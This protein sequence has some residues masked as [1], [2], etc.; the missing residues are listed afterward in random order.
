MQTGLRLQSNT[1]RDLTLLML[2]VFQGNPLLLPNH[3]SVSLETKKW[4]VG[5]YSASVVETKK[6][7]KKKTKKPQHGRETPTRAAAVAVVVGRSLAV[8][9]SSVVSRRIKRRKKQRAKRRWRQRVTKE[10][11][12]KDLCNLRGL[13]RDRFKAALDLKSVCITSASSDRSEN[14]VSF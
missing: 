13:H 5:T 3:H 9:N 11:W 1:I 10:T 7:K 8:I 2:V 14:A 12:V 4:H 6:M